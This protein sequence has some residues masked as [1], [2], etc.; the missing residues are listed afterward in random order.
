MRIGIVTGEIGWHVQDLQR[1]SS[2]ANIAITCYDARQLLSAI[3]VRTARDPWE[4]EDLLLIRSFPSGT[5][6]QTIFRLA[7]LYRAERE[8][9]L[10]VN[11]PGSF[12][13][14]VDKFSTTARLS[15]AGLSVP[16][17]ICCQELDVAMSAFQTLG[18][19]VVVKP[20]FGSEG[21]GLVR[22]SDEEM[23]FRTFSALIQLGCVAYL[24]KFIDHPGYDTRAFVLGGKVL[25]AMRRHHPTDWRTNLAQGATAEAIRLTHEEERM[26]VQAS[27]VVGAQMAGVDLLTDREG[28]H[29]IIEVNGVP[30]WRGLSVA[31]GIDVGLEIVE[32]LK[33]LTK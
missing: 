31:S 12:E 11:S 7:T 29:Y 15:A 30:G 19:D 23:A 26:A 32:W 22:V 8:G 4:D 1:A 27:E 3:S 14:C 16:A 21:K 25:A 18:S 17:T 24:Q 28:K 13:A 9:K 6:E 10:V 2:V 5:L 33:A 20:L